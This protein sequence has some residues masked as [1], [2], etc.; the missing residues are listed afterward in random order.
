[1]GQTAAPT[2]PEPPKPAPAADPSAVV[3]VVD[4]KSLTLGEIR[5]FIGA[6]PQ[7]GQ[8][9]ALQNPEEFIRQFALMGKLT[10]LAEENKLG[11]EQPYKAQLE[12]YRRL[13]L[14][15][16]GVNMVSQE[17]DVKEAEMRSYFEANKNNF[18]EVRVK[19]IYIPF[20]NTPQRDGV[21]TKSLSEPDARALAEKLVKDIRGGVDFVAMVKEHSRDEGSKA[22]DGDFATLKM[23]DPIPK[24]VKDAVFPMQVG[25]V[26]NP[27]RQANGFYIFRVEERKMP[28][29]AAVAA[30]LNT[31]VHEEKFGKKMDE[32][33]DSIE[34]KD[35]KP[36]LLKPQ[37]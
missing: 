34:I 10:N 23:T 2:K 32:I 28:E 13:V 16:A 30:T 5:T 9:A 24:E 15:N 31:K 21:A 19:V 11:E 20:L 17:V 26:S 3:A 22:K 18:A 12:Y 4:G 37:R 14:S 33:R 6:M 1:M 8:A 25:E 29:Y 35:L 36:E 27:V 7:Q